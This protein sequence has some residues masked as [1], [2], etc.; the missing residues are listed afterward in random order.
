MELKF[1]DTDPTSETKVAL[2]YTINGGKPQQAELPYK[3]SDLTLHPTDKNMVS[4][5]VDTELHCES[6]GTISNHPEDLGGGPYIETT[7]NGC[8]ID[9]PE[10]NKTKTH[11]MP[12]KLVRNKDPARAD[13]TKQQ[14]YTHE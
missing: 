14:Q 2:N 13:S 3:Y 11:D 9:D 12:I 6:I 8:D 4:E 5:F 1:P 7:F 10:N